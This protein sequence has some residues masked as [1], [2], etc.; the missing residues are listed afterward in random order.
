[1]ADQWKGRPLSEA[2]MHELMAVDLAVMPVA[3]A[4]SIAD[5]LYRRELLLAKGRAQL[6]NLSKRNG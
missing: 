6:D 4:N 1:M 5:E 3:V 2:P